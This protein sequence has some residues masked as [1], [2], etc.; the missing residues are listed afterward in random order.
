MQK[1]NMKNLILIFFA[2]LFIFCSCKSTRKIQTA[3]TPKDTTVA[4]VVAPPSHNAKEDTIAFINES[5]QQIQNRQIQ[6]QTFSAKTDVDYRELDGKKY[7]VTVHIRMVKDSVIWLL[8]NGP[9]GIEG[10]RAL[11]TSDSVKI[12]D[13]QNKTYTAR[14]LTYLQEVTALPLDLGS[15]QNLLIGNAV[16]FGPDIYAYQKSPGSLSLFSSGN[17]FKNLFT[18]G[19]LTKTVISS[20]L[21]DV[22][23][24]H[25]RTCYL[26]YSDYYDKKGQLFSRERN[27]NVAEKKKIDIK[28]QFKQYEFNEKLSF[29]FSV[30]EKYK[31]N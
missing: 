22:N 8:V 6:Y 15:L 11:I 25:N 21:D 14:S 28:I 27:I 31:R 24:L 7:S 5:Y 30:S 26:T 10:L 23:V 18:V 9:L 4:V 1:L 16:F 19:D 13:K 12:L 17:Y 2:G 29:P 3:I 20:K